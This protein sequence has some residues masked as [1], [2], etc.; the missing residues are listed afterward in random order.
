[1]DRAVPSRAGIIRDRALALGFDAIGFCQADLGPEARARLGAFL[2][3]GLHGDMGWLATRS[4][5]RSQPRA[6]WPA[7]RT[8]IALALSY[9]PAEDPL[10][11]LRQPDRGT[12]SVYARNRDYHDLMKGRLKHLAAFIASRFAAGV[13]VF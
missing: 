3:A 9:A 7:A 6:L 5:Q 8:V 2:A 10:A 11:S 13:K 4:E 12:I 1:V